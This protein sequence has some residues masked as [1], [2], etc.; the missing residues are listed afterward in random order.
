MVT[1]FTDRIPPYYRSKKNLSVRGQKVWSVDVFLVYNTHTVTHFLRIWWRMSHF[2]ISPHLCTADGFCTSGLPNV[3]PSLK[4]RF[5]TLPPLI[6]PSV[7]YYRW[8]FLS[9]T[10]ITY[11]LSHR[12]WAALLFFQLS[13]VFKYLY[14][15][16]HDHWCLSYNSQFFSLLSMS[17]H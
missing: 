13:E 7:P 6:Y 2:H 10:G 14:M 8:L 1:N 3:H 17:Q 16:D 4:W 15:P 11:I 12:G 9:G 5:Y